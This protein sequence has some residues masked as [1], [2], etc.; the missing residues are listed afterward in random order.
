MKNE[1]FADVFCDA[2]VVGADKAIQKYALKKVKKCQEHFGEPRCPRCGDC[3]MG[4]EPT[5]MP[6]SRYADVHICDAC[7]VEEALRDYRHKL[8]KEIKDW[9]C[10]KRPWWESGCAI[11]IDL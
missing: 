7:S 4:K 3:H 11:E 6:I 10:F 8:P 5:N 2:I 9:E 1:E